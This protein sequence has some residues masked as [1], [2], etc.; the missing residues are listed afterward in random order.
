LD[1]HIDIEGNLAASRRKQISRLAAL[2]TDLKETVADGFH[3]VFFSAANLAL[4]PVWRQKNA[5]RDRDHNRTRSHALECFGGWA[6]G[7]VPYGRRRPR[8]GFKSTVTRSV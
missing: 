8:L 6:K 5:K 4:L 1:A 2:L 7:G 3:T